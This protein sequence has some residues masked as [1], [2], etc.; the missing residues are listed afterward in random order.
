M[1]NY[2]V[3]KLLNLY[4]VYSNYDWMHVYLQIYLL[5]YL[6]MFEINLT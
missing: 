2:A 3:E 6:M 1:Y 4:T 5:A